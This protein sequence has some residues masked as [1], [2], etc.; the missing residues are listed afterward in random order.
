[1]PKVD[2]SLEPPLMN[3]AGTLGFAPDV[4]HIASLKRLGAFV[5]N[6]ISLQRRTPARG[7]RYLEFP[8]GF[9][10]HSGYPNP[11][12][13]ATIRRH[14]RRWAVASLP[15]FV[16]LMPLH[17]GELAQMLASLEGLEGVWG[18]EIGLPPETNAPAVLAF[19]QA[20][21]G[22]LPAI[23]RLPF[24]HA[25]DLSAALAA[26][27]LA[28]ELAAVSLAPPRG[29]LPGSQEGTPVSGRIYGPAVFPQ[30][31]STV[32]AIVALGLPV[33]ASGGLY[34]QA[35]IQALRLAGALAVQLDAVLW[36]G[37]EDF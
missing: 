25:L 17:P 19:T 13:K 5:T 12:L 8:G 34:Q 24:E 31:F 26:S 23:L 32:R 36:R 28:G 18:V 11:G 9:L 2:L 6:P 30:A 4:R 22:E 35:Q 21:V 27:P 1:L 33:I 20:A 7:T 15:V 14:A 37:F 29:S 16:H 10:L 3:A